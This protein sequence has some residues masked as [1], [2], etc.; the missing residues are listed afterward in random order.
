M[1]WVDNKKVVFEAEYQYSKY[2]LLGSAAGGFGLVLLSNLYYGDAHYSSLALVST[3][4]LVSGFLTRRN[5]A[6]N[7]LNYLT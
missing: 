4:A 3:L 5:L 2:L 7:S 6:K 1:P